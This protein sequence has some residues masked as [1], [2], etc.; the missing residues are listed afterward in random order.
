MLASEEQTADADNGKRKRPVHP[1]KVVSEGQNAEARHVRIGT[2]FPP[3][4]AV[5]SQKQTAEAHHVR[6]RNPFLRHK[7]AAAQQAVECIGSSYEDTK[8]F[9]SSHGGCT[10][11]DYRST[12]CEE[13]KSY[14][15]SHVG[16]RRADS[17]G[18]SCAEM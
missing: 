15:F 2:P 1:H 11:A 8:A 9:A 10:R 5:A 12:S 13:T 16:F 17:R 6:R 4:M 18:L 14:P 7:M 3:H